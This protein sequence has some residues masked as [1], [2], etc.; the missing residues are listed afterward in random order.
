MRDLKKISLIMVMAI[1]FMIL[2]STTSFA[3]SNGTITTSVNIQKGSLSIA[4]PTAIPFPS[5]R[6]TGSK[7]SIST[8]L[9]DFVITDAT[10]SGDGWHVVVSASQLQ[11][12]AGHQ[13]PKGSLQ[14]LAPDKVTVTGG[15]TSPKPTVKSGPWLIDNGSYSVL[16]AA[17]NQGMGKYTVAFPTNALNLT[18][19]PASVFVGS[20][21]SSTYTS[22]ITWTVVTGP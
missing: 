6:L 10:G 13:L 20:G 9:S 7:H 19:N 16:S 3:A 5:V 2:G 8:N 4:K 18:L 22:T 17:K 1:T 21:G 12:A 11:D 15:T 14:L